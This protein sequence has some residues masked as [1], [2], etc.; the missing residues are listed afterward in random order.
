LSQSET[1]VQLRIKL[2]DVSKRE[3][4]RD[5]ERAPQFDQSRLFKL[6]YEE[7]FGQAVP[8][9]FGLLIG[10]FTF[11]RSAED[12]VLLEKLG[13]IASVAHAPFV[14]GAAPQLLGL[15]D[16]A[17]LAQLRDLADASE[18]PEFTNWRAFRDS[19]DARYVALTLPRILLRS[20]YGI[21]P[22]DE[23]ELPYDEEITG[24]GHLL[25]ANAAFAFGTC[26]SNAFARY[27]WCG[28]LRGVEGGG[29]VEGLPTYIRKDEEQ[30]ETRCSVEVAIDDRREKEISDLGFMPVTAVRGA[31]Y[32]VFFSGQSCCRPRQYSLDAT[33]NMRLSCQLPYILT[34]SRFMHYFKVIAHTRAGSY[35]SRGDREKLLNEWISRYVLV[36]DQASPAIRAKYPLREARI[37]VSEDPGRP[38]VYRIIAFLRPIFQLDE[39]SV[40]LRLVGQI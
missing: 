6:V 33:A 21:R 34:A 11:R 5:F 15:D 32:A 27:G 25:W 2:L 13:Q 20:P 38:G 40:S 30:G 19:E 3:L 29:I 26:V 4:L 22:G 23:E 14:A 10:D 16:F 35:M 8:D 18:S 24:A 7:P 17:D 9:P 12:V 39:L 28:S 36:D 1:G 31:D 37:E